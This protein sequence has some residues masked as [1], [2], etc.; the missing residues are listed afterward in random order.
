MRDN[1]TLGRIIAGFRR[2]RMASSLPWDRM[3][4]SLGKGVGQ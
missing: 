4:G 2:W 3:R 1:V